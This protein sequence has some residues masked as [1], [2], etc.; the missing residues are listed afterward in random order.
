[1]LQSLFPSALSAG[2]DNLVVCTGV[3]LLTVNLRQ[4]YSYALA[5][6]AS[7]II[8]TF[9][10]MLVRTQ[11]PGSVAV[12]NDGHT[13]VLLSLCGGVVLTLTFLK[14]DGSGSLSS[15]WIR[16]GLPLVFSLDNCLLGATLSLSDPAASRGAAIIGT[17]G[18]TM[19]VIGLALG[20]LLRLL[21]PH[22][23]E[24][25]G[26]GWFIVAAVAERLRR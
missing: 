17:T 6:S 10:G 25:V 13:S 8:A 23:T 1:M 3:G 4:R 22:R 11:V 15:P 19:S 2:I 12:L 9:A 26:S 14:R 7:E 18:A 20:I 16:F 21:V 24:L 5:F